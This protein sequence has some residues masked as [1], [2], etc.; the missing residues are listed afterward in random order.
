MLSKFAHEMTPPQRDPVNI[1]ELTTVLHPIVGNASGRAMEAKHGKA[2][3]FLLRRRNEDGMT[4]LSADEG[5]RDLSCR[6][7]GA[8]GFDFGAGS[9]RCTIGPLEAFMGSRC[10][11]AQSTWFLDAGRREPCQEVPP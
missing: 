8:E 7:C 5:C 4:D 11:V 3:L 10:R 2:G 1:P 6:V 9:S